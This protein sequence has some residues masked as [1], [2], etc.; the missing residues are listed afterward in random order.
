MIIL[1]ILFKL[2]R[3]KIYYIFEDFKPNKDSTVCAVVLYT[4]AHFTALQNA[5]S[6][7]IALLPTM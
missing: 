7:V 4:F 6:K 2:S 1:Q 3:K 5:Q